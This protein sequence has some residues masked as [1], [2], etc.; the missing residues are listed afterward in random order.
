MRT[1]LRALALA[2]VFQIV[3]P[4][5]PAARAQT[6]PHDARI[7]PHSIPDVP[8]GPATIRGRVVHTGRDEGAPGIDVVLYALQASGE[9]GAR[10]LATDAAG[11]FAFEGVSNAPDVAYL[12]GAR[13][14]GIPFPG[15]RVVFAAGERERE[16]EIQ[17]ADLSAD[18]SAVAVLESTLRVDRVG[19]RLSVE[20]T[21]RLENRGGQTFYVPAERRPGA[22]PGFRAELPEGAVDFSM[23][24]GM[25]PEGVVREGS[26][27][28]FYG[29]IYPGLQEI[30]FRYT[31]RA[32][33]EAWTLA[34]R[35]PSGARRAR[36]LLPE[37]DAE[38]Q[39]TGVK[40][41][42]WKP[43]ETENIDGRR[44]RSFSAASL[45]PGAG[46]SLRLELPEMRR[47]PDALSVA[48]AQLFLE[49]DPAAL[50][51]REVYTLEVEGDTPV[52]GEPLLHVSLPAEARDIRFSSDALA[53]GLSAHPDGGLALEGP[54]PPGESTL[55]I[56][57]RLPVHEGAAL[58]ERRFD[59]PVPL[60]TVFVADTGL[61]IESDRLHRRR[62][63]RTADRTY[64]HLEAFAVDPAEEIALRLVALPPPRGLP[65][66]AS[67]AFVLLLAAAA[68]WMLLAPLRRAPGAATAEAAEE[69]VARREREAL[70]ASI[71][72][73]DHDFETGKIAEA[74][75]GALRDD[76][77]GRAVALLRS[78][79]EAGRTRPS[80]AAAAPA[81]E[82]CPG[83]A[84]EARPG[85]RF[86]SQCGR[87]LRPGR[88]DREASL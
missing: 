81:S 33:G 4:G 58:L 2:V 40:R 28:A 18:P 74:D 35:F 9:A 76:L 80:S 61:R 70:Y 39:L 19:G 69:S 24:L 45:A 14:Q 62:P 26:Q 53:L 43:G 77:R 63:V 65:K 64:V 16:I 1:P 47:D 41:A 60:L 78:E 3:S 20:E 8:A 17:I 59:R 38:T 27:V 36:L 32:S 79:R 88:G 29:P 83:C 84:S 44:Y 86:C 37:E 87:V 50:L 71:R 68:G 31:L 66:A 23:P 15:D 21:H 22:A 75:Y 73:L 55:E 30:S 51:A 52:V 48:E 12:V 11:R 82:V 72:D 42:A 10:R 46:V 67:A 7:D 54:L 85:D 5:V 25:V 13:Y 49:L 34:K 6:A 56:L 57:Y